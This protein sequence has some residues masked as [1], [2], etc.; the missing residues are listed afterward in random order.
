MLF[1]GRGSTGCFLK[2]RPGW[3]FSN[4][5]LWSRQQFLKICYYFTSCQ[6][7]KPTGNRKSIRIFQN[8]KKG[9]LRGCCVHKSYW[10]RWIPGSESQLFKNHRGNG[11]LHDIFATPNA[12][13]LC[14][15]SCRGCLL[16]GWKEAH[17][18]VLES[19]EGSWRGSYCSGR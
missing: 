6:W 4:S 19:V 18:E 14:S 9:G 5:R 2:S 16:L 7:S 12:F 13:Q 3:R 8:H 15:Q 17:W 11:I 1:I 10:T